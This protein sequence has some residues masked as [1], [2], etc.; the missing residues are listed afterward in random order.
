[1]NQSQVNQIEDELEEDLPFYV[2]LG[3]YPWPSEAQDPPREF[4]L[5]HGREVGVSQS[6]IGGTH[7]VLLTYWP[8]WVE[9][10]EW[11]AI[12][13]ILFG[14]ARQHKLTLDITAER[15][16]LVRVKDQIV[17]RTANFDHARESVRQQ[18]EK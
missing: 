2:R 10:L 14:L 5:V 7:R 18:I 12:P 4:L 11:A 9:W 17:L 13:L 3:D 6:Y 8:S 1:M 16:F 15:M